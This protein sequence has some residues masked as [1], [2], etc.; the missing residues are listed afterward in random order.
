LT[1]FSDGVRRPHHRAGPRPAAAGTFNA[2]FLLAELAEPRSELPVHRHRLDQPSHPI[3]T[4]RQIEYPTSVT[5][6][7]KPAAC[8]H[9][10]LLMLPVPDIKY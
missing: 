9:A 7:R 5:Y 3:V 6:R 1:A 4:M 8:T 10:A 2:P